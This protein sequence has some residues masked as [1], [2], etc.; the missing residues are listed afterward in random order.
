MVE[1]KFGCCQFGPDLSRLDS[2]GMEE[3]LG[4]GVVAGGWGLRVR[5]AALGSWIWF[6]IKAGLG[7]WP[8]SGTGGGFLRWWVMGL[9][10]LIFGWLGP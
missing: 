9:V 8:L 2:E 10:D 6:Q 5:H 1:V 7:G 3:Q 4:S